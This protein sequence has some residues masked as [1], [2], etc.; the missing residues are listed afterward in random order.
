MMTNKFSIKIAALFTLIG[1]LFCYYFYELGYSIAFL[2]GA[3]WSFFNLYLMEKITHVIFK[4]DK[5]PL[6]VLFLLAIKFPLL[7]YIGYKLL[8]TNY[9]YSIAAIAGF[10]LA[11]FLL[12]AKTLLS[13]VSLKL[14]ASY[15][16]N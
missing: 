5:S 6:K 14:S 4:V 1:A 7:Y 2:F 9:S 16:K 3:L 8:T 12:L 13:A 15:K 10:S 11:L